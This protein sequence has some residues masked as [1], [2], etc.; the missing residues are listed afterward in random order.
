MMEQGGRS[1]GVAA[2]FLFAVLPFVLSA[3]LLPVSHPAQ[4]ENASHLPGVGLFDPR[5]RA[6][7]HYRPW[8]AVARLNI[9]GVGL[10]TAVMVAPRWAVTAAHCLWHPAL[11]RVVSP[12]TLHILLGYQSGTWTRELIPDA[13]R[14]P[15]GAEPGARRGPRGTDF[16]LLHLPEPVADIVSPA[17]NPPA[18]GPQLQLGG[19][20]GDRAEWLSIDPDCGV[21]DEV[22]GLDGK[23]VLHHRCSGTSG[24]SG[25]ALLEQVGTD[26][27]ELVGVQIVATMDQSKGYAVPGAAVARLLDEVR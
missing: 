7:I 15:P 27:W 3:A 20:N 14:F 26:R 4:A 25:G 13:I 10:C 1:S 19:F 23:P 12:A 5:H 16:A 22:P 18:P 17:E 2:L 6:D 24:T 9:A 21:V 11:D 8:T